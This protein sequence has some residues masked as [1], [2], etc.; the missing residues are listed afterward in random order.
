MSDTQDI[1]EAE[2]SAAAESAP[3]EALLYGSPG[4]SDWLGAQNASIAF[5][6][7]QAGRLFMIGRRPN[8]TMRAHERMIDHCQGLWTD[9]QGLWTS[10]KSV[11]WRFR[12]ALPP[13]ER[14]ESGAD[15][16]F[17]PR[18]GRVTG[19]IDV[20]DIGV[21]DVGG[22]RLGPIFV[23]TAFNCLATI[24]DVASFRPLWRPPFISELSREDRCHLNGLAMDGTRAAYVTAVSRS[25]VADGWRERRR[26]GGVIVDVDSGEIVASGFSMPHSP[27]LHDGKLFVLN[28][29]RGEFGTVDPATG[30]F[31]SIAFCPGYARGLAFV[32][33]FAIIGLSRPRGNKTFEGL[34]LDERLAAKDAEARC[35]LIIVDIQTGRTVEWLRFESKIVELYDVAAMPGVVQPEAVGFKGDGIGQAISAEV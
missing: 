17:V 7:Y 28:S 30:A 27:R 9:G 4:L 33:R 31:T 6:T 1:T 26:D 29:G 18:E 11:L 14:G 8:G 34:E 15:R 19:A 32:G 21:G 2:P 22:G 35:G 25:D 16:M 3:R 5:T 20:H 10:A 24:S 13:G 23:N 12:N